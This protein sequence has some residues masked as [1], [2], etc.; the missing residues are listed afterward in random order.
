M[1]GDFEMSID[2]SRY[3]RSLRARRLRGAAALL[4]ALTLIGATNATD[5]DMA[6]TI[7]DNELELREMLA[8]TLRE[9]T[10]PGADREERGKPT[11]EELEA[12]LADPAER[13]IEI[14]PDGSIAAL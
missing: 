10:K 8:F 14:R 12:L 13:K 11:I 6:Q 7:T 1:A 3:T 5:Q 2:P 4:E 9:L